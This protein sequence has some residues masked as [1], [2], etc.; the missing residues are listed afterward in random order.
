[1]PDENQTSRE[2]GFYWVMDYDDNIIAQWDGEYWW[3]A[4][5]EQRWKDK[6]FVRVI[7]KTPIQ[8]E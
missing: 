3:V 7:S 4:G 6:D 2:A 5:S 1:M 8:R